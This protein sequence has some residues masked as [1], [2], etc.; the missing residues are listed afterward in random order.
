MK[1]PI[2]IIFLLGL[3]VSC[4][5]SSEEK[6][7]DKQKP[8]ELEFSVVKGINGI[9]DQT[10]ELDNKRNETILITTYGS[11]WK[12]YTEFKIIEVKDSAITLLPINSIGIGLCKSGNWGLPIFG[13][14]CDT[15]SF[16]EL[17]N[18]VI[19]V[20]G[21]NLDTNLQ[22]TKRVSY[23]NMPSSLEEKGEV[24]VHIALN[25]YPNYVF[26]T[27]EFDYYST[28][29]CAYGLN[30]IPKESELIITDST[31]LFNR[32]TY[33]IVRKVANTTYKR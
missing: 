3:M 19:K 6:N 30:D 32:F 22:I 13:I 28:M 4:S 15:N 2:H 17:K 21:N 25:Q 31:I 10:I 33:D 9:Q 24:K 23:Y 8:L 29:I 26:D 5:P 27:L 18:A 11:N 14:G 7:S 1:Y 20:N 12:S 16:N